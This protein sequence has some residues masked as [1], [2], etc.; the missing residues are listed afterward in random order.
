MIY[1]DRETVGLQETHLGQVWG[2]CP[3]TRRAHFQ[4]VRAND[5]GSMPGS[6]RQSTRWSLLHESGYW[7]ISGLK[8]MDC[9]S[10]AM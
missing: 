6:Y 8:L 1:H 2:I 9:S 7:Q 10:H 3:D 4:H 5:R